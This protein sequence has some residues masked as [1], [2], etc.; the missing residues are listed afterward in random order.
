MEQQIKW[1]QRQGIVIVF[2]FIFFPIGLFL[3][4]KSPRFSKNGKLIW[5]VVIALLVI[6]GL[7]RSEDED[8]EMS[9]PNSIQSTNKTTSLDKI[10]PITAL[11]N[12]IKSLDKDDLKFDDYDSE[13]KF[14]LF[15]AMWGGYA[16]SINKYKD[17]KN[18]TLKKL[19]STLTAKVKQSQ[20][21]NFPKARKAYAMWAKQKLW[22][23]NID[24]QLGG[25][26]NEIMTFTAGIFADNKEIKA[27]QETIHEMLTLLRFKQTR[28][29]WYREDDEYTYYTIESP[30]DSEIIEF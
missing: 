20:I 12:Q 2:L 30:K 22:E 15:G 26:S 17:S 14:K 16:I 25:K 29:K 10:P 1:Y 21:K 24:V 6:T 8:S 9:K 23:E 11:E 5:T 3:L 13:D 18:D 19:A 4:W 7:S 27:A 28:Y